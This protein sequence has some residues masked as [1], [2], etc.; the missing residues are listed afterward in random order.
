[1]VNGRGASMF[2]ARLPQ[3]MVRAGGQAGPQNCCFRDLRR[4]TASVWGKPPDMM[5]S[6]GVFYRDGRRGFVQLLAAM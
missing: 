6:H 4:E 1:M 3:G 2:T 5:K